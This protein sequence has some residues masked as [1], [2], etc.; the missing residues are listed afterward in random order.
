MAAKLARSKPVAKSAKKVGISDISP[1]SNELV[2]ALSGLAGAGCSSIARQM[3]S[4][5]EDKNYKVH[6]MKISDIIAEHSKEEVPE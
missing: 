5:L 3:E 2:I 6:L 4:L 1:T